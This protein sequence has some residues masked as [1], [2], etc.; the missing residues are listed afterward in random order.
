MS[1]ETLLQRIQSNN[2]FVTAIAVVDQDG[3]VEAG[4]MEGSWIAA[5]TALLVPLRELLD[6]TGTELGCGP[7]TSTLF[8]GGDASLALAD[9]DGASSV[10]VLGSTHAPGGALLED[11]RW[12]ASQLQSE[13]FPA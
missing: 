12:V 7:F 5:A 13:E 9:V 6:R 4:Q 1:I 3:S 8:E 11:A 10:L 2:P